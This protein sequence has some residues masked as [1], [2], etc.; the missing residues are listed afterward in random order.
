MRIADF[1]LLI[2]FGCTS[3]RKPVMLVAGELCL[4]QRQA[5]VN[6][7]SQ[8]ASQASSSS[9][10]HSKHPARAGYPDGLLW[11]LGCRR[12]LETFSQQLWFKELHKLGKGREGNASCSNSA[13]TTTC[14]GVWSCME[15]TLPSKTTPVPLVWTAGL[16]PAESGD[17][18]AMRSP[19]AG[20][21]VQAPEIQGMKRRLHRICQITLYLY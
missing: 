3:R 14:R 17:F 13:W 20:W 9:M 5:K 10:E 1:S 16:F 8:E 4:E 7:P 2:S 18:D 12:S 19:R 21:A 11:C 6:G 15:I